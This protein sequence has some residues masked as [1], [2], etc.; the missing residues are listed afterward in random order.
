MSGSD[1]GFQVGSCCGGTCVDLG[2]P[3]SCGFCRMACPIGASC[4]GPGVATCRVSGGPATCGEGKAGSIV[5]GL[6]CPSGTGCNSWGSCTMLDC[7]GS[8]DGVTCA[9][10]S[11]NS[12]TCCGG[13]CV[14][15]WQD[16][17]NCGACG[18]T[19]ASGVCYGYG[20]CLPT[21]PTNDCTVT[22]A[23]GSVCL[24]GTC[25]D[26]LCTGSGFPSLPPYCQAAD[27][28]L[29]ACCAADTCDDLVNDPLNCGGCGIQCPA[30]QTCALGVCSG[31]TAACGVG[32]TGRFC[33]LD[34]GIMTKV[35]CPGAG[36]VDVASDPS[37][38]GTCGTTCPADHA[39]QRGSC[40]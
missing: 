21:A 32:H 7:A 8:P 12:G 31:S 18:V 26:S 6:S 24:H 1:G 13:G 28:N 27:G 14:A 36:C 35:C 34:G 17:A 4:Y 11:S 3:E 30:G 2:R 19:C 20:S 39:C 37:N 38:C 25:F 10:G 15:T 33:D 29:G 5:S 9:F 22:C 16:P 23:S 40:Q